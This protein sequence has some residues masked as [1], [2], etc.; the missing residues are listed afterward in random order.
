MHG[1]DALLDSRMGGVTRRRNQTTS[2][3]NI[4]VPEERSPSQPRHNHPETDGNTY[5]LQ[6]GIGGVSLD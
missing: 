2:T 1:I 4:R 6:N 3:R 5:E